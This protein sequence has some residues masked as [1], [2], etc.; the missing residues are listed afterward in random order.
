MP[1]WQCARAPNLQSLTEKGSSYMVRTTSNSE[2]IF[3]TKLYCCV[4]HLSLFEHGFSPCASWTLSKRL[5]VTW[6]TMS[7]A[8]ASLCQWSLRLMKLFH[9]QRCGPIRTSRSK[10]VSHA[11]WRTV[12][13]YGQSNIVLGCL[14]CTWWYGANRGI[15]QTQSGVMGEEIRVGGLENVGEVGGW[16]SAEQ[17]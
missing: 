9:W 12:V 5:A 10:T 15:C 17:L 16:G 14:R 7:N 6:E 11:K 1:S 13:V 8:T 4:S 2:L 3:N